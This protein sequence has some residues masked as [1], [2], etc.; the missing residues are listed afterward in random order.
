MD[1][2]LDAA[3]A[4]EHLPAQTHRSARPRFEPRDEPGQR[5]LVEAEGV[6]QRDVRVLPASAST[7]DRD[8][9]R[10]SS[11]RFPTGS[12]STAG[13]QNRIRVLSASRWSMAR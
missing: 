9:L 10:G 13:G 4:P 12:R 6:G 1:A 8:V 11:W 7:G 3:A 5:R 2:V